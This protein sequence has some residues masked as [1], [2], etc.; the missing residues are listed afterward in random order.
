MMQSMMK[1]SC[2]NRTEKYAHYREQCS[3]TKLI[4]ILDMQDRKIDF[5]L[6]RV[7]HLVEL[8]EQQSN[9]LYELAK[10]PIE[11][12][13]EDFDEVINQDTKG[14]IDEMFRESIKAYDDLF[15]VADD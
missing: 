8:T 15:G 9:S 10:Q 6:N 3:E 13:D 11:I 7:E 12:F 5:L 2:M 4:D 14:N 1:G